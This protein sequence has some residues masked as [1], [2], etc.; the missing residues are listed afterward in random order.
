[1]LAFC[2]LTRLGLCDPFRGEGFGSPDK[3]S[4]KASHCTDFA[5]N[6]RQDKKRSDILASLG[7]RRPALHDF[8]M[9]ALRGSRTDA[10]YAP[11][12]KSYR[13]DKVTRYT[14][15]DLKSQIWIIVLLVGRSPRLLADT[16]KVSW[17]ELSRM[18]QF[19]VS[20]IASFQSIQLISILVLSVLL[21]TPRCTS[22]SSTSVKPPYCINLKCTVKPSR[23]QEFLDLI[24]QNQRLTLQEPEALQYTVGEDVDSPNILHSRAV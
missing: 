10:C 13:M 16:I 6:E 17:I 9:T 15:P 24:S 20:A 3:G 1:M 7:W 2:S 23:R 22:F 12:P 21:M 5:S 18:G 19:G 14:Y 8:E 11:H 4:R